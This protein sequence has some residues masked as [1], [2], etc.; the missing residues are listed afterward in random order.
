[1]KHT[2]EWSLLDYVCC[3]TVPEI[4]NFS[5]ESGRECTSNKHFTGIQTIKTCDSAAIIIILCISMFKTT[6]L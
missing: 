6:A 2:N 5:L 4:I 3:L 1:M